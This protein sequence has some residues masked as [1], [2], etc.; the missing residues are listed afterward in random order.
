MHDTCPNCGLVFEREPGYF[1]GAM[2]ISY[3]LAMAVMGVFMLGWHLMLPDWDLGIIVL[4][5]GATFVP[6]VPITFRYSRVIWM[7]FDHWAWPG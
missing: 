5:A 3:T 6:L 2:Y 1:M 4:L 7:H